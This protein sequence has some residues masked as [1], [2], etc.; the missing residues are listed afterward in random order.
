MQSPHVANY[1][2]W[3][4]KTKLTQK[5]SWGIFKD[6]NGWNIVFFFF[7]QGLYVYQKT[8]ADFQVALVSRQNWKESRDKRDREAWV[9]FLRPLIKILDMSGGSLNLLF[10]IQYLL[11]H[12]SSSTRLRLVH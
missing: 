10:T 9:S 7:F 12:L 2:S 3:R 6:L 5:E 1:R 11:L 4:K 8:G